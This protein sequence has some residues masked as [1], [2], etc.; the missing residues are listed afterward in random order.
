MIANLSRVYKE[1]LQENGFN[2]IAVRWIGGKK[3][4]CVV[5]IYCKSY[6]DEIQGLI[7]SVENLHDPFNGILEAV[8]W[9]SKIDI[10]VTRAFFPEIEKYKKSWQKLYP[11]HFA[12]TE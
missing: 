8:S 12:V 6:D 5:V 4:I 11:R 2:V 9:G 7:T 1:K 3:L 10:E